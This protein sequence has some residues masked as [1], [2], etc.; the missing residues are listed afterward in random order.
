MERFWKAMSYVVGLVSIGLIFGLATFL[1]SI[2]IQDL[3]LWLHL[4]MGKFIVHQG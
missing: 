1:T 2:E 3:D 4:A